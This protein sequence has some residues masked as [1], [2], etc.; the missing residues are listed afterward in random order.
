[1]PPTDSI[2][3]I[4]GQKDWTQK[5]KVEWETQSTGETKCMDKALNSDFVLTP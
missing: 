1:M 5:T 4:D 3:M 2:K